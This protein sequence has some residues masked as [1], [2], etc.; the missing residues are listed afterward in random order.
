M[1]VRK[2]G[3][4]CSNPVVVE[5]QRDLLLSH[6]VDPPME[7]LVELVVELVVQQAVQ[8]QGVEQQIPVLVKHLFGFQ[9]EVSLLLPVPE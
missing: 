2:R 8:Y 4:L 9:C 7:A 1:I 5:L 6:P 3:K